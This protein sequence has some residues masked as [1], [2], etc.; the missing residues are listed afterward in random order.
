MASKRAIYQALVD[1]TSTMIE[2][3]V[4]KGLKTSWCV[5]ELTLVPEGKSG[6]FVLI[7]YN[8][9]MA[10]AVQKALQD[11]GLL[12]TVDL[13]ILDTPPGKERN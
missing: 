12:G 9:D 11:A 13:G 10:K 8:G 6:L 5:N 2:K 1:L 4:D 7:T 3:M